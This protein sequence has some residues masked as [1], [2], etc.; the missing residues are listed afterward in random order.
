[1]NKTFLKTTDESKTSIDKKENST[2]VVLTEAEEKLYGS[3]C[4]RGYKKLKMLGKGG[5]AIVWLCVHLETQRQV[6]AK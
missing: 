6:A 1:L 5:Y 3:R 4:P 2:D